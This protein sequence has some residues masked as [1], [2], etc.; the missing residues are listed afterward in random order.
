M[1]VQAIQGRRADVAGIPPAAA[2][3]PQPGSVRPRVAVAPPPIDP[4]RM[5][6]V[7][8][9]VRYDRRHA[10]RQEP[11]RSTGAIRRLDG[12][13]RVDHRGAAGYILCTEYT[14]RRYH[15]WHPTCPTYVGQ[16]ARWGH[17][18]LSLRGNT[19]SSAYA[20]QVMCLC[21]YGVA[22]RPLIIWRRGRPAS[23]CR[24]TRVPRAIRPHSR[25]RP[26]YTIPLRIN[27][28][29]RIAPHSWGACGKVCTNFL[30]YATL[31]PTP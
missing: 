24:P 23:V 11:R 29:F 28:P 15:P 21:P 10:A 25:G 3:A 9:F 6:I 31:R 8:L 5:P 22:A 1:F 12:P 18:T 16:I 2:H 30:Y 20:P 26:L 14:L 7:G 27:P 4:P 19:P 17:Q 13:S